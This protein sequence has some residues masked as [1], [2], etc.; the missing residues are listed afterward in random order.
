VDAVAEVDGIG[1]RSI[2]V[3]GGGLVVNPSGAELEGTGSGGA[4]CIKDVSNV[5]AKGIGAPNN[6]VLVTGTVVKMAASVLV[7]V[8]VSVTKTFEGIKL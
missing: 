3:T 4:G 7:A 8:N 2:S 6:S 1:K 5:E